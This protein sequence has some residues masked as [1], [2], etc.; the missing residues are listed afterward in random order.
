[1]LPTRAERISPK[2]AP[3]VHR[4]G[5]RRGL[6][7]P[8]AK[9]P[10]PRGLP[11][12]SAGVSHAHPAEPRRY[13]W[14]GGVLPRRKLEVTSYETYLAIPVPVRQGTGSHE[15]G[16]ER[17][18]TVDWSRWKRQ[19]EAQRERFGL[20]SALTSDRGADIPRT[21]AQRQVA[22]VSVR[23]GP[24]GERTLPCRTGALWL[25]SRGVGRAGRSG[26]GGLWR[27]SSGIGRERRRGGCCC[28]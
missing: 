10:A 16:E 4:P 27:R 6:N 21:I 22:A 18:Q 11:K 2:P 28:K 8:R 25:R 23:P 1:V 13:P 26:L 3:H 7:H 14:P 24:L 17:R 19:V 9:R 12:W 15:K 5:A 20:T